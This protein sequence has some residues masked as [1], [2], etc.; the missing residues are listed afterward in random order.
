MPKF[1][2]EQIA[3]CPHRTLSHAAMELLEAIGLTDWT[4]DEV[5]AVGHVKDQPSMV[6][7]VAHLAFNYQALTDARELEILDYR[8][9]RSWMDGIRGQA[10]HFGMHVSREELDEWKA[11]FTDR[12]IGI[13]QEVDTLSHT[14]PFLIQTGRK[15]HYCI[16]DT[17]MILGVDLKFIVRVESDESTGD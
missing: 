12:G 17:R 13:A 2:I 16:F 1:K 8:S 14:N 4:L 6:T 9:G 5:A 3:L 7:N 11:F 15:Y 10:S